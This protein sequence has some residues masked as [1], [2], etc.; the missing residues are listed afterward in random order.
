MTPD[1]V[2]PTIGVDL[3]KKGIASRHPVFLRLG[4][5]CPEIAVSERHLRNTPTPKSYPNTQEVIPQQIPQPTFSSTLVLGGFTWTTD[6][7]K[8]QIQ[9][10]VWTKQTLS[11]PSRSGE[12]VRRFRS[13]LDYLRRFSGVGVRFTPTFTPSSVFVRELDGRGKSTAPHAI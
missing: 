6:S 3:N 9:Q 4:L 12:G 1:E 5:Q 8:L 2:A 11:E 7:Q 13:D 10:R